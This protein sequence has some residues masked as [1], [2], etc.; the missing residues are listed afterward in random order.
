MFYSRLSLDESR[1][2]G[3]AISNVKNVDSILKYTIN[4]PAQEL[5][6]YFRTCKHLLGQIRVK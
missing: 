3:D 5:D 2:R 4:V 6:F 1:A